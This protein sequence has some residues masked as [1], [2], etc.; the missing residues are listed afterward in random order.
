MNNPNTTENPPAP[1]TTPTSPLRCLSGALIAGTMATGCYFLTS[2]IAQR[3]AD[4]PIHS[5]NVTTI[6][7][8]IAVRT[9]VVGVST[10]ATSIFALVAVGLVALAIQIAFQRL[11]NRT[12]PPSQN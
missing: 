4:K 11:T 1:I 7:I 8:A 2:S 3:F 5:D 10:L 6:N 9:L 12:P